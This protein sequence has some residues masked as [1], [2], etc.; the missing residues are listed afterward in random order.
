MK[1]TLS[2]VFCVCG[3]SHGIG[4]THAQTQVLPNGTGGYNSYSSNGIKQ[5]LPNGAGGFNTYGS[6]GST[7]ILSNG[8]GG[9]NIYGR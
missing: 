7:Q 2:L 1:T 5:I 6:D 8:A 3:I 9:F 4:V